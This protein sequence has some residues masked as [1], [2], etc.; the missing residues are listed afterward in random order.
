MR[1]FQRK[2]IWYVD[3][4]ANGRRK[5]EKVGPNKELAETVLNK[6]KTQVAEKKFP[7]IKKNEKIRFCDM[8]KLF[9]DNY[10]RH[11]KRSWKIDQLTIN[12]LNRSLG[13]KFLYE[14]T[15]LDIEEFKKR[16]MDE[17]VTVATI[18]RELACLR[19]IFNRAIEWG[20]YVS[21]PPKIKLYRKNN[22]QVK[23]FTQEQ[24]DKLIE[25]AS[26]PLKSIISLAL[27]RVCGEQKWLAF[28]GK[29]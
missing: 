22:A 17:G 9:I 16:R 25:I 20:K 21:I 5:S 28:N 2:Q 8:A 4:Y 14:I 7:D 19:N 18:N 10:A 29:I 12:S 6:R 27:Q 26:E 15:L 1:I 3:Y 13:G 11:N 23:Y 24:A